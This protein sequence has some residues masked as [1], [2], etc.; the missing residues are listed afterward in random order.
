MTS[1][2]SREANVHSGILRAS[3]TGPEGFESALSSS[4]LNMRVAAATDAAAAE[5]IGAVTVSEI[6]KARTPEK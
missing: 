2:N 3:I 6:I 5:T 4:M 1:L